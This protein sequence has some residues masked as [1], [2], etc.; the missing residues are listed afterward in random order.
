MKT[1]RIAAIITLTFCASLRAEPVFRLTP[2][3]GS[4]YTTF[5]WSIAAC[6]DYV[7]VGAGS[8]WWATRAYIYHRKTTGWEEQAHVFSSAALTNSGK[9]GHSVAMGE[10]YAVVGA[11]EEYQGAGRAY[12]FQRT[13]TNW[14]L[15]ATFTPP[16]LVPEPPQLPHF[17]RAVA[18][19]G[20]IIAVGAPLGTYELPGSVFLY[21]RIAGVWQPE[22]QLSRTNN[23]GMSLCG[24]GV[25]VCGE[26]VA[27]LGQLINPQPNYLSAY[28]V[29]IFQK[30][31]GS[32]SLVSRMSHSERLELAS[33]ALTTNAVILGN[34]SGTNALGEHTGAAY[35]FNSPPGGWAELPLRLREDVKF[36]GAQVPAAFG[37]S[38]AVEGDIA[39]IGSPGLSRAQVFHHGSGD[40]QSYSTLSVNPSSPY[41]GQAVA[42]NRGRVFVTA[43]HEDRDE[44]GDGAGGAAYIFG[45]LSP[46]VPHSPTPAH[47][48]VA[49]PPNSILSWTNG[50][51]SASLDLYF[52]L[53]GFP[54]NK[55]LD[56]A[57]PVSTYNPGA[58]QPNRPYSWQV[59]C[60]NAWGETAGPV[61][62]F[63]TAGAR[64]FAI[65]TTNIPFGSLTTNTVSAPRVVS[66]A[67][68]GPELII[69][70][71]FLTN[72]VFW[73]Q[74]EAVGPPAQFNDWIQLVIPGGSQ[75]NLLVDFAPTSAAHC[76]AT[77]TLISQGD[78]GSEGRTKLLSLSGDGVVPS[79]GGPTNPSPRN[80]STEQLADTDLRWQNGTATAAV[81][82]LFSRSG[83]TLA[84]LLSNAAPV[85]AYALPQLLYD[86]TYQWQVVCR[87]AGGNTPGPV[88]TFTTVR[89]LLELVSPNGGEEWRVGTT[90]T[91]AWKA[92]NG[93][94][95]VQLDLNQLDR[96]G[97][98]RQ[99]SVL[100]T[101]VPAD[102]GSFAWSIDPHLEPGEGYFIRVRDEW[103]L[104]Y[105]DQ[106]DGPFT[107]TPTIHAVYPNGGEQ[108]RAGAPCNISWLG[109][110][111]GGEVR[112]D[113]LQNGSDYLRFGQ[114]PNT[115]S[116]VWNVPCD[117]DAKRLQAR[118][119]SLSDE[120]LNDLS[121]GTF[122]VVNLPPDKAS[123][124]SPADR[125]ENVSRTP[126]LTWTNGAGACEVEV[127]L[128]LANPPEE[129]V[130]SG[131]LTDG[132]P[133]T[134]VLRAEAAH[135]WRV[136]SRNRVGATNGPVWRFTTTAAIQSPHLTVPTRNGNHLEFLWTPYQSGMQYRL[137]S[138]TNLSVTFSDVAAV[139]TNRFTHT[140]GASLPTRFY[141][142][143]AE[144][145]P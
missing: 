67:N 37:S 107:L 84:Y 83:Q 105:Y 35:L 81:D 25:A 76:E 102:V 85:T 120:S 114:V 104:A 20:D 64:D 129:R 48:D 21:R 59:I 5:G 125:A 17:G 142:V 65:S 119:V 92:K 103:N 123:N 109:E 136:V 121:D 52:N 113:I 34:P 15:A 75:R 68:P 80:G 131:G 98:Q 137:Q 27:V 43:P 93:A 77:V 45:A 117:L 11:P 38:V 138:T 28:G 31:A 12:V 22:A 63:G 95:S 4:P 46:T 62:R 23:P 145:N 26:T 82:L 79:A 111:L 2:S 41:W 106:S 100:A 29:L 55:V 135:Y 140:N 30:A 56:N 66:I 97:R 122:D 49:A 18:A 44:D 94:K 32:W 90:Q 96:N 110:G 127:W 133:V 88:W 108:V 53:G 57:T 87:S 1:F 132:F 74:S 118:V 36:P 141:R 14:S 42:L 134:N 124:P 8:N 60:S 143:R 58:L 144:A 10:D 16:K 116:F 6:G 9:F 40:W 39:V 89:P 50:E 71:V 70:D 99:I 126:T 130:Y 51:N 24:S 3:D 33:L 91:I 13:G 86:T 7:I 128:G 139:R 78:P 61:W 72:P 69:L 54:T 115:G 73:A 19:H 112:L 47:G 101:T